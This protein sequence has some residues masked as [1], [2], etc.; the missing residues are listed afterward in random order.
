MTKIDE[1]LPHV[2]TEHDRTYERYRNLNTRSSSQIGF[3]G[4]IIA[5]LGVAFNPTSNDGI[6]WPELFLLISMVV[7]L[8]SIIL[9]I[10]NLTTKS[11]SA[12]QVKAYHE[13]EKEELDKNDIVKMY[14][15]IIDE[16][17]EKNKTKA[18]AL[19]I[20]YYFTVGGLAISFI[21]IL[22]FMI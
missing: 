11:L 7:L 12:I 2:I 4:V 3:V 18:K 5:I 17:D 21:A 1:L 19:D 6:S 8:V 16:L 14:L 22:A 15:E 13:D 10:Y 20:S 9:S